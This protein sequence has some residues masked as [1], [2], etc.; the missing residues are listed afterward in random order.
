MAFGLSI[1]RDLKPR[2]KLVAEASSEQVIQYH[3]N[4]LF[5]I[6]I[7]PSIKIPCQRSVVD[8][9][10]LAFNHSDPLKNTLGHR[11]LGNHLETVRTTL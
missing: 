3:V 11:I 7:W 9:Y 5:S 8:T 10:V 4:S 2:S 6:K 1:V